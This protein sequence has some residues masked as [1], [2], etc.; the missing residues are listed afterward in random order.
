MAQPVVAQRLSRGSLVARLR[1]NESALL[2][3]YRDIADT[4]AAGRV[5]TPAAEWLLDNYHL[6]EEQIREIREDL[7]PSYYRLL[8][9]LAEGPL[10]GY[11]RV[12]GLAWAFVAHT[13][14]RF[15]PEALRRFVQAY[16]L[17]Q[18]LTIG[19]LW[20]VAITLRIVLVENLRRAASRIVSNR[21]ARQEA[22]AVADRL[23]GVNGSLG[24]PN[25]PLDRDRLG[26]EFQPAFVVQ[27]VQ[28]L[29]DQ[30][31]RVTPALRW[32]EQ[33][34]RAQ[35]QTPEQM[36]RDEHQ[37][38]GASNVTV[39]NIITSMRLLSDLDWPEFFENVSL[40]D[41]ELRAGSDF[42][43][44]DFAS[45]NLYRSAIEEIARGAS[46]RSW[47]SR[48]P[49]CRPQNR[50]SMP[51]ATV[52]PGGG[53]QPARESD[54]GYHLIASGRAAFKASVGYRA[55]FSNWSWQFNVTKGARRYIAAIALLGGIV[56]AAPLLGL[57]A[58][59]IG[60][61]PL[62][63]LALLGFIPAL[64]VAV[65]LV[66]RFVTRGIGATILPGLALRGG[67]PESLRTLVAVPAILTS[68]ETIETLLESLEVHYLSSPDGELYFAL[69]TD[70]PDAP[71][72]QIAGD[73][74]L[75]QAAAA[76]IERLNRRYETGT[77]VRASTCFIAGGS[78][79]LGSGHGWASSASAASCTN[80]IS[81][82]AV[83]AIPA[84]SQPMDCALSC[85]PRSVLSLRWMPIRACRAIARDDWSVRWHTPSTGRALMR[86]PGG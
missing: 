58:R 38:Q 79:A 42:A 34:L 1:D 75:L 18:P 43:A 49:P 14:S 25:I 27:L 52:D 29:R 26:R 72:E 33:R 22:D 36:V 20:A 28:R 39:R 70:W 60:G 48:R 19:E 45:R 17:V 24:E 57:H 35:G 50:T 77:R 80:S 16:Q 73:E 61:W 68:H 66:N 69:L 40:V 82:C 85:R 21:E 86:V 62:K 12:F 7:P 76:G 9:K 2:A 67:V 11:P 53:G 6:V 10:L 74:A 84:S 32:L 37:K 46:A 64:D 31:P 71:S 15:E 51:M 44:M 63:W 30:D 65:A 8:P 83:R 78:G 56:L 81:C 23:L 59:G 47:R 5:I 13:D 4:V 41:A 55:S 54:P 3:A